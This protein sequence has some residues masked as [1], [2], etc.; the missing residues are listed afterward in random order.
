MNTATS[1]V[2]TP[3]SKE[4]DPNFPK[5]SQPFRGL[6]D[7]G[8]CTLHASFTAI[9]TEHYALPTNKA[10]QLFPDEGLVMDEK[11]PAKK[12]LDLANSHELMGKRNEKKK[13]SKTEKEIPLPAKSL[14]KKDFDSTDEKLVERIKIVMSNLTPGQTAARVHAA[15]IKWA[16]KCMSAKVSAAWT[17]WSGAGN[18]AKILC[19]LTDE[20][21]RKEIPDDKVARLKV[22]RTF[23]LSADKD[24]VVYTKK[25]EKQESEEGQGSSSRSA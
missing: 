15:G 1:S 25:E 5:L 7:T 17:Y 19:I 14:D 20:K 12:F 16:D 8:I 22:C 24:Y 2:K 9:G 6:V 23:P 4:F 11:Y 18:Y 13:N 10:L 21:H 3:V